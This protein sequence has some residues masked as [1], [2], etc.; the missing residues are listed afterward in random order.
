MSEFTPGPWA[1]RTARD[2]SG[3]V[4]ITAK[5]VPNVIAECFAAIRYASECAT[6]EAL[7]NARLIAAAPDLLHA[8][9]LCVQR[10]EKPNLSPDANVVLDAAR[11]A[12]ARA[13]GEQG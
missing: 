12:I 2:G 3:D 4:G 9:R 7:A 10:I 5:G 1:I 8:V 6:E 11:A 13:T